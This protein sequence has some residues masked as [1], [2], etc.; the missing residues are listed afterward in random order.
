MLYESSCGCV[1]RSAVAFVRDSLAGWS[2]GQLTTE[3][4]LALYD[5]RETRVEIPP[6]TDCR[7]NP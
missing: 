7:S 6:R 4:T 3:Q 1:V 2:R 5:V